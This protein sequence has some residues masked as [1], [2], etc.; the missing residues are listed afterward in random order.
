MPDEAWLPHHV[1]ATWRIAKRGSGSGWVPIPELTCSLEQAGGLGDAADRLWCAAWGAARLRM[2]ARA[3]AAAVE[4]RAS[5]RRLARVVREVC[6][7]S[8]SEM[9]SSLGIGPGDLVT[10]GSHGVAASLDTLE[11]VAAAAA[12]GAGVGSWLLTLWGL[13]LFLRRASGGDGDDDSEGERSCPGRVGRPHLLAA[14][15]SLSLP[16]PR[17]ATPPRSTSRHVC[18]APS[19]RGAARARRHLGRRRGE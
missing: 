13:R 7:G 11:F 14:S 1:S 6:A 8:A 17:P 18:A 9:C 12:L 19:G 10:G 4:L 16:Q 15:S 2:G 5:A 3:S